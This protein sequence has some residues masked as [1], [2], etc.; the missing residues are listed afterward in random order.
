M[1][2]NY[3]VPMS[4]LISIITNEG[5]SSLQLQLPLLVVVAVVVC[6]V[7]VACAA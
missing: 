1:M 7:D 6:V 3:C 5:V 2:V 4:V